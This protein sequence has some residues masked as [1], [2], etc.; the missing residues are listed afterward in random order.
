MA[1]DGIGGLFMV[2][3]GMLF[4]VVLTPTIDNTVSTQLAN[5]TGAA[6]ALSDLIPIVWIFI[7]LGSGVGYLA[8]QYG[9]MKV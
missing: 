3:L 5:L 7:V 9:K 6:S 8:I 2:F 4:G 1:K